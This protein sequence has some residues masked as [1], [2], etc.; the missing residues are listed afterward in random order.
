MSED[1]RAGLGLFGRRVRL[2]RTWLG[3]AR[4]LVAGSLLACLAVLVV[5]WN[6]H[7]MP[8]FY[9]AA[10]MVAATLGWAL[11]GYVRRVPV[12]ALADS[13]DRRGG[14][15]DRIVT[16]LTVGD[17]AFST[18]LRDDAGKHL[19]RLSPQRA[20]PIRFGR[21]QGVAI[22]LLLAAATVTLLGNRPVVLSPEE[23]AK[24][25]DAADAAET[26]EHVIQPYQAPD[27]KADTALLRQV[28]EME[29]LARDLREGKADREQ[30]MQ[31]ANTAE[32]EAKKLEAQKRPELEQTVEKASTAMEKFDQNA[33]DMPPFDPMSGIKDSSG[34]QARELQ[35]Q[36]QALKQ[37]LAKASPD[38]VAALNS[39]MSDLQARAS[40]MQN[41]AADAQAAQSEFARAFA[42][43]SAGNRQ[44]AKEL[45]DLAAAQSR[46]AKALAKS[47]GM[48][49]EAERQLEALMLESMPQSG[50]GQPNPFAEFMRLKMSL[51]ATVQ[52]EIANIKE[53]LKTAT[54][55]E[56]DRLRK[57][58]AEL[59][60][61][62]KQAVAEVE[63][64]NKAVREAIK[65]LKDHKASPSGPSGPALPMLHTKFSQP[66][67]D[68]LAV[69]KKDL[70]RIESGDDLEQSDIDKLDRIAEKLDKEAQTA[71]AAGDKEKTLTAQVLSDAARELAANAAQ[72]LICK[73]C[74]S[75][76]SMG[77][78]AAGFQSHG[79]SHEAGPGGYMPTSSEMNSGQVNHLD[80][81]AAGLG[82]T[83]PEMVLPDR[84][85]G[86]GPEE[87][88]EIKGPAAVGKRSAVPYRK[89]LPSY[90]RKA[91]AALNGATIPKKQQ[92][93]VRAYFDSLNGN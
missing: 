1:I 10:I 32:D 79:N 43:A 61:Q 33:A 19:L 47:G 72:V 35:N 27:K 93:R 64:Q 58:L 36:I 16:A 82:K 23:R 90:R 65:K 25:A 17:G 45:A 62:Y 8:W 26:I 59:E 29:K 51:L 21:L 63:A 50:G 68:A 12:E 40:S 77:S 18:D 11:Y 70:N 15:E 39:Q 69:M 86:D 57:K 42:S 71:E 44:A 6:G 80:K 78:A 37:Q 81:A 49:K 34:D 87:Y 66:M 4:G 88:I 28:Q 52:E 85:N 92:K 22:A 75:G 83:T 13:I 73:N 91:E 76:L 9:P 7:L 2:V 56:A 3:A 38:Q 41:M 74:Q 60:D 53:R 46:L 89:V 20:Y 84:G 55:S 31:Q 24:Q 67:K 14:L 5:R 48:S 54:G 30:A